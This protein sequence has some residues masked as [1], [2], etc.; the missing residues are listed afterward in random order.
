MMSY[1]MC[2]SDRD[3]TALYKYVE[4]IIQTVTSPPTLWYL[5]SDLK[6]YIKNKNM[7]ITIMLSRD[8]QTQSLCLLMRS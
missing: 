3:D 4:L 7:N 1:S 8:T 5:Y 2:V 6:K